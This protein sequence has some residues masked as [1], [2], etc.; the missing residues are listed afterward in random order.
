LTDVNGFKRGKAGLFLPRGYAF[1]S[2][3][4]LDADWLRSDYV[5]VNK[6]IRAIHRWGGSR[7][8]KISY[9]K[10][11][12]YFVSK[13]GFSPDDLVKLDKD[14]VERLVQDFSDDYAMHGKLSS[15]HK[16][17]Q[18]LRSFFKYNGIVDLR[19][20]GYD[21][22]K[23]RRPERVP[24]KEEVYRMAYVS[25]LR[26]TATILCAFQSGLRNATLRALT[27]GDLKD[28][29]ESGRVQ[30]RV[31][32][33]SILKDR[34][35]G[36]VKE[37]VEY[38]TFFGREACEALRAYIQ[39]R[40]R[41]YGHIDDNEPLFRAEGNVPDELARTQHLNEDVFERLVKSAARK[42]GIKEWE[43]VR[44]HSLRKTFRAT[45]DAGYVDG[46]QMAEDDKEYLM[47]HRLPSQKA[48][49]HNANA[50]V[51]EQRYMK[52]NWSQEAQ[53]TKEA[54][55]EMIRTFA[56]SLGIEEIEMKIQK[57]RE[58][59]PQLDEIKAIGKIVREEIGIKPLNIKSSKHSEEDKSAECINNNCE[60][61]ENRI[62]SESKLLP[63]LNKGWDIVKELRNGKI[64]VRRKIS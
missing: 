28:Q 48:P 40:K 26:D 60:R 25:K 58:E 42:A 27:Y 16:N 30:I 34:V 23:A 15:A 31:H 33:T 20:H 47:G 21:Y 1:E 61:Y 6:W 7:A 2:I 51:L 44:F 5:S 12:V 8:T 57:L 46:G 29:I 55:I 4:K 50:D 43:N 54:K 22:R 41:K 38:Y 18:I 59:Q 45:L 17:L 63:H 24:T 3:L 32:V 62:V 39:E 13:V 64:V 35:P 53:I 9:F 49:Y 10:C 14:E 37:G 56:K 52:I 19:V 36:A 11:L